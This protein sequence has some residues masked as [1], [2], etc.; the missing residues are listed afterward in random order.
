VRSLFVKI[1]AWF[2]LT[3]ALVVV[4]FVAL[5]IALP[6]SEPPPP[7]L[8]DDVTA[9]YAATAAEVLDRD[10]P[11]ALAAYAARIEAGGHTRFYLL[12]NRTGEVLTGGELPADVCRAAAETRR[13]PGPPGHFSGQDLVVAARAAGPSGRTYTAVTVTQFGPRTDFRVFAG[14]L[15]ARVAAVLATAGLVCFALARYLTAPILELRRAAARL[16]VGDLAARVGPSVGRRRDEL[17][18]LGADFDFM[19][20]RIESLVTAERTLLR[21]ISHELRSPLARLGVALELAR[22]DAGPGAAAA[23]DRIERESERLNEM[24]GRLLTVARLETDADEVGVAPVDLAALVASVASDADFEAR[25]SG[26]EV[27]CARLDACT[28]MGNE[29]LL[30][31]AVENVVRNAARYTREGT[32]VEVELRREGREAVVTVR[33]RGEGVPESALAEIFRP[34]YRV[35]DA[36]D[37][38]TG[39]VGLGL[40][41]AERAARFHGGGVR[42]ENAPDGGLVVEIR[43]AADESL[44]ALDHP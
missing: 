14:V 12:D 2:W 4:V 28:V 32:A 23:L 42:A 15:A 35:A 39:G 38:R 33:D 41:I 7:R 27:R 34:F 43:V 24:I 8:F 3:T 1:F 29:P 17:A 30:R 11:E 21:D 16:A 19:A 44:H 40:A 22:R 6:A 20:A 13:M 25:A 36:R 18:E 9:V 5:T 37:R 26:R 10:G 31:S